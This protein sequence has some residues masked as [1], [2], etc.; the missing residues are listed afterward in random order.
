MERKVDEITLYAKL[1]FLIYGDGYTAKIAGM[2][3][4]KDKD[5]NDCWKFTLDPSDELIK[6]YN[7][8]AN[9]NGDMLYT[10]DIP[11]EMII[12]LN[13]DPSW[14]RYLCLMNYDG[15]THPGI[16]KLKGLS[17]QEE[18]IKLKREI[19]S[20]RLG[21]EVAKE[22]RDLVLHNLPK[23]FKRNVAPFLEELGPTIKAMVSKEKND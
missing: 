1:G 2:K 12:I 20:L 11:Y 15:E 4:S 13:L 17:Q 19:R 18:I 21:E 14:T 3:P 23:H 22:Q 8:N 6:R 10:V 5:E 16:E 9:K 7:L